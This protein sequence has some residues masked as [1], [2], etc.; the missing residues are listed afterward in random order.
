MKKWI[1]VSFYRKDGSRKHKFDNYSSLMVYVFD[2]VKSLDLWDNFFFL[3]EEDPTFMVQLDFRNLQIVQKYITKN[4]YEYAWLD[5]KFI[6]KPQEK[7]LYAID[8]F[9]LGSRHA[10]YKVLDKEYKDEYLYPNFVKIFHCLCN[11]SLQ[12]WEAERQ[13]YYKCLIH[14]GCT[15]RELVRLF[16]KVLVGKIVKPIYKITRD[17]LLKAEKC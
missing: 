17:I 11:Q 15:L 16:T 5:A 3:F 9:K 10:I 14:R 12:T 13:F 1:R 8:F 4:P 7:N 2:M 6:D